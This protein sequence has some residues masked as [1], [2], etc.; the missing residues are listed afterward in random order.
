MVYLEY[1]LQCP[2]DNSTHVSWIKLQWIYIWSIQSFLTSFLYVYTVCIFLHMN[3]HNPDRDI[4]Q[5]YLFLLFP[6][7]VPWQG[8]MLIL[9]VLWLP[10]SYCDPPISPSFSTGYIEEHGT[11]HLDFILV[12]IFYS[13]L[14]CCVTNTFSWFI[15]KI[16][17][18]FKNAGLVL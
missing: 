7:F 16:I 12:C 15:S 10:G 8:C 18:Y 14:H 17:L 2:F 1:W 13:G 3:V 6:L 9:E 5:S 11:T 4:A